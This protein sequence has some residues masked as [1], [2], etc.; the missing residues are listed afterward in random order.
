MTTNL[1]QDFEHKGKAWLEGVWLLKARNKVDMT[2]SFS[3]KTN[4]FPLTL[5]FSYLKNYPNFKSESSTS[6]K[7]LPI[8]PYKFIK[9]LTM[10]GNFLLKEIP[11]NAKEKFLPFFG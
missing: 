3:L 5:P 8:R 10:H 1:Q 11:T 9:C 6:L 7:D 4:K 2:S